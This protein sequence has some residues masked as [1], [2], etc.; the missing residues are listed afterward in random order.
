M[1]AALALLN[2]HPSV[3]VD[4]AMRFSKNCNFPGSVVSSNSFF[5]AA[6]SKDKLYSEDKLYRKDKLY[7]RTR[8]THTHA[9]WHTH[10]HARTH[11][12][13]HTHTLRRQRLYL[14]LLIFFKHD[15]GNFL[16]NVIDSNECCCNLR[17]L[18][19]IRPCQ[20]C[21]GEAKERL[22]R[23]GAFRSLFITSKID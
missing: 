5:T 21:S 9:R 16:H 15:L 20:T 19:I 8:D 12:R 11:T 1:S 4:L 10:T 18:Y 6:Y 14:S 23:M 17:I 2:N 22:R 13:T 7:V 3:A